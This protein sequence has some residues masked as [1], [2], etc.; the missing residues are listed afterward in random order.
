MAAA[1][2][3]QHL[4]WDSSSGSEQNPLAFPRKSRPGVDKVIELLV[5][6]VTGGGEDEN[7]WM[8]EQKREMEHVGK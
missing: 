5:D 8:G 6:E 7:W 2:Q 3:L 4:T 1:P